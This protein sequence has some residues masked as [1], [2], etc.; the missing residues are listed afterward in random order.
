MKLATLKRQD[1]LN[2]YDIKSIGLY[3]KKNFNIDVLEVQT[4]KTCFFV[5]YDNNRY[6]YTILI[7]VFELLYCQDNI[8]ARGLNL[9]YL[10]L[11]VFLHEL[12][13]Y[14]IYLKYKNKEVKREE[15]ICDKY[16]KMYYRK[17]I[18]D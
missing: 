14:K 8:K 12:C 15:D 10:I 2:I 7:N 9:D 4:E 11:Q 3:A 13:H 1:K 18:K 17:F 16:A 5:R 6:T